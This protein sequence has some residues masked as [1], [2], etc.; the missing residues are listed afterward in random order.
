MQVYKGM[1]RD[2]PV[3]I[4]Q[5]LLEETSGAVFER[6][7]KTFQDE[8]RTMASMRP[9]VNVVLLLGITRNAVLSLLSCALSRSRC[10]ASSSYPAAPPN[11]CIIV[12]F[13]EGRSVLFSLFFVI[14]LCSLCRSL[15]RRVV[16]FAAA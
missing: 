9:H 11:L 12:E 14:T 2:S 16:V 4:K 3:A 15:G 6:E 5:L 13:C 7:L 8:A 1:W 10:V